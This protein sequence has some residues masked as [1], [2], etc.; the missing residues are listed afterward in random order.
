MGPFSEYPK[1]FLVPLTETAKIC[2]KNS[3]IFDPESLEV[4]SFL[5]DQPVPKEGAF[6]YVAVTGEL[7]KDASRTEESEYEIGDY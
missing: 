5:S 2:T 4:N 3:P 1:E 6:C 7:L